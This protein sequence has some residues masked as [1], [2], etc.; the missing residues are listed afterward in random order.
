MPLKAITAA[1]AA[2]MV[3][4]NAF[5]AGY[6]YDSSYDRG[7]AHADLST[8]GINS[9]SSF[10]TS[11]GNGSAFNAAQASTALTGN[12]YATVQPVTINGTNG[13]LSSA[14]VADTKSVLTSTLSDNQGDAYGQADAYGYAYGSGD[15]SVNADAVDRKGTYY[16][17]WYWSYNDVDHDASASADAYGEM[18]NYVSASSSNGMFNGGNGAS[19][20][21][22]GSGA[23]I[24]LT[25]AAG[26]DEAKG[27]TST[28]AQDNKQAITFADTSSQ[29]NGHA[30][31][32][33][34]ANA[35]GYARQSI[36]INDF[37]A[38]WNQ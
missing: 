16:S 38:S 20:H 25:A 17:G 8:Y 18:D 37:A 1:I 27:F 19:L 22:A 3:S 15:A 29:G 36:E 14:G 2:L 13:L 23:A 12:A 30:F 28:F 26:A 6:D 10:S 11:Y 31:T 32:D 24:D 21:S 5:A 7:S 9:V 33:A 35:W 4:G 34:E